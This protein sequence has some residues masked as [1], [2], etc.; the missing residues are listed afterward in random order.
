MY[1]NAAL[2]AG[3]PVSQDDGVWV[4]LQVELDPSVARSRGPQLVYRIRAA[5]AERSASGA[6][7]E[8]K[9]DS[10]VAGGPEKP[11]SRETSWAAVCTMAANSAVRCRVKRLV[12]AENPSAAT[13]AP[14]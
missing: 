1:C 6:Y 3:I 10:A 14:E 2:F 13:T 11:N 4:E 7:F 5:V 9:L 12:G 8:V